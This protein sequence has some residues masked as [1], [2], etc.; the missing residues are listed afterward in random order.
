[1]SINKRLQRLWEQYEHMQY[2]QAHRIVRR[3]E[4]LRKG[5][6]TEWLNRYTGEIAEGK[7]ALARM[8]QEISEMQAGGDEE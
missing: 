2:E 1:M 5:A 8:A 4:L 7:I 3:M 6:P